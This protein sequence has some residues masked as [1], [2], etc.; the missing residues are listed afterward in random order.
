MSHKLAKQQLSLALALTIDKQQ[1]DKR[2]RKKQQRRRKAKPKKEEDPAERQR[3][4]LINNLKYFTKTARPDE[5]TQELLEQV[6]A[7]ADT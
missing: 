6:A 3:E 1:G 5:K 2:P 7:A 4:V